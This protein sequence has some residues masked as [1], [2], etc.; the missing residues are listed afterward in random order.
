MNSSMELSKFRKKNGGQSGVI[1]CGNP[2]AKRGVKVGGKVGKR[3]QKRVARTWDPSFTLFN[4]PVI[5]GG[6]LGGLK[7]AKEGKR[8]VKV[9]SKWPK[10]G[11]KW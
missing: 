4:P 7:R 10:V 9:G 11:S 2:S 6:G 3:G 1:Y 5:W 8:G